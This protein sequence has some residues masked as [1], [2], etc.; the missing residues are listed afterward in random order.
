[1]PSVT[2]SIRTINLYETFCCVKLLKTDDTTQY[3]LLW[4][5]GGGGQEDT[6]KNRLQHGMFLSMARDSFLNNRIVT[7]SFDTGSSF[8]TSFVIE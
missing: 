2:G 8:V 1:M 7:L 6:A 5:Y 3:L 4:S